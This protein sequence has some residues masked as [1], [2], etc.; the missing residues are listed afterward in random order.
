MLGSTGKLYPRASSP[1]PLEHGA[2][3]VYSLSDP[4]AWNAELL[5]RK[6]WDWRYSRV[7]V[8]DFNHIGLLFLP[9][10]ALELP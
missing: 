1:T 6:A 2:V 10:A 5:A 8:L 7:E 9:G 3:V 4:D